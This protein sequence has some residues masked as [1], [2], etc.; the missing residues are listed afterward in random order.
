MFAHRTR[1]SPLKCKNEYLVLE[2]EKEIAAQP[3]VGSIVWAF[4]RLKKPRCREMSA[5]G[6][7]LH[8][9][10]PQLSCAVMMFLL[11]PLFQAL[12]DVGALKKVKRFAGSG[13][14]AIVATRLA[15]GASTVDAFND[16]LLNVDR[17]V[18][19]E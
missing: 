15:I 17:N 12:E 9:V 6:Y 7:A 19:S 2:L 16:V 1:P 5:R 10:C 13:T 4:C 14:G 11:R 18:Q 8:S 3:V